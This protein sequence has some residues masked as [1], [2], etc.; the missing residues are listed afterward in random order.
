MNKKI[1]TDKKNFLNCAKIINKNLLEF[2]KQ[3]KRKRSTKFNKDKIFQNKI[4]EFIKIRSLAIKK[5][6]ELRYAFI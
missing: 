3:I 4:N 5:H 6:I 1:I 2:V